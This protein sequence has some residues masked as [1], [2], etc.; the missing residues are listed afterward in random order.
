MANPPFNLA[1][2]GDALRQ[3]QAMLE[4]GTAL[5][6]QA[7]RGAAIGQTVGA[8]V[9]KATRGDKLGLPF[10]ALVWLLDQALVGSLGKPANVK[11]AHVE[12]S[13][14]RG[15]RAYVVVVIFKQ[16]LAVDLFCTSSLRFAKLACALVMAWRN[17]GDAGEP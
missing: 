17:H 12:E 16:D 5:L 13:G 8:L 15:A 11:K 6:G 2:L 9:G 7:E 10:E 4:Q 3:A 1:P 14:T